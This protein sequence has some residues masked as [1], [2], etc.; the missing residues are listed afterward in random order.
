MFSNINLLV[1]IVLS[2]LFIVLNYL[3]NT[4]EKEQFNAY[5]KDKQKVGTTEM[6]RGNQPHS[7]WKSGN[8]NYESCYKTDTRSG[9]F[10]T[11]EK[12]IFLRFMQ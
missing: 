1:I 12:Y 11:K 5:Y 9:K 3:N 10:Y 7:T 6:D 4:P 2:I 8:L